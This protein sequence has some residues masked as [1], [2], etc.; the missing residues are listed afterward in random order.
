MGAELGDAVCE[1]AN[2]KAAAGGRA[3][4]PPFD[5]PDPDGTT[6]EAP[7]APRPSGPFEEI[8][9]LMVGV[10]VC[11]GVARES[12]AIDMMDNV[13]SLMANVEKGHV[14]LVP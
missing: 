9:R 10:E 2:C 11:V 4:A 5:P 14:S 12:L 13:C 1:S 7:G 8:P 3:R 6:P